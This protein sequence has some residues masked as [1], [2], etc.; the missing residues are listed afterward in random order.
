MADHLSADLSHLEGLALPHPDRFDGAL[1]L[2]FWNR[3]RFRRRAAGVHPNS[4]ATTALATRNARRSTWAN[5][6]AS[7]RLA[8]ANAA[9][10]AYSVMR[11]GCTG[12]TSHTTSHEVSVISTAN[13][14]R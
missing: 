6:Y 1:Q 3:R 7:S 10:I 4:L 12:S 9:A 5:P 11:A 2:S 8:A 13:C 14:T